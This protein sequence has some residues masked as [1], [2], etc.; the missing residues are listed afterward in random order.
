M[1]SSPSPAVGSPVPI[2]VAAD[3]SLGLP[4]SAEV[5]SHVEELC[6][7]ACFPVVRPALRR[8]DDGAWVLP[9]ERLDP[10]SGTLGREEFPLGEG[11]FLDAWQDDGVYLSLG[12]GGARIWF[13]ESPDARP[14]LPALGS[15]GWHDHDAELTWSYRRRGEGRELVVEWCFP[16][17]PPHW[18]DAVQAAWGGE[19]ACETGTLRFS[20]RRHPGERLAAS[21][22]VRVPGDEPLPLRR[23]FVL[24]PPL[25]RVGPD[26]VGGRVEM[27]ETA[28]VSVLELSA[29]VDG[30]ETQVVADADR[31]KPFRVLLVTEAD[32]ELPDR[33][34]R[35][36]WPAVGWELR[37]TRDP[38]VPRDEPLGV[39]RRAWLLEPASP[40]EETEWGEVAWEPLKVLAFALE[41][42]GAGAAGP[43]IE[44]VAERTARI[45]W[46]LDRL[47]P[48]GRE[49]EGA[50]SPLAV[51]VPEAV[52]ATAGTPWPPR[53][54]VLQLDHG[55]YFQ[56]RSGNVVE[57]IPL[58]DSA[59]FPHERLLL[60][61]DDWAM[62]TESG[63][64]VGDD[65]VVLGE[66][67]GH[68][69]WR[70]PSS[71]RERPRVSP[72][73]WALGR[74]PVLLVRRD[75]PPATAWGG[76]Y[77]P[78][79]AF[80]GV[81]R[82]DPDPWHHEIEP[83]VVAGREGFSLTA[84]TGA[85]L[86]LSLWGY[87]DRYERVELAF[88]GRGPVT[89]WLAAAGL[90]LFPRRERQLLRAFAPVHA[91][92]D[93]GAG[94]AVHAPALL[95]PTLVIGREVVQGERLEVWPREEALLR[96]AFHT[97]GPRPMVP[98]SF[99][100][101]LQRDRRHRQA[102]PSG[103]EVWI[104]VQHPA[105]DST[106]HQ[107]GLLLSWRAEDDGW[108]LRGLFAGVD[109]LARLGP[110][111]SGPQSDAV[112]V[113]LG[114]GRAPSFTLKV[115]DEIECSEHTP[116]KVKNL[117]PARI[118]TWVNE[119]GCARKYAPKELSGYLP[120]SRPGEGGGLVIDF[121]PAAE[122]VRQRL[123]VRAW[124]QPTAPPAPAERPAE[125][126]EA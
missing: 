85:R 35:E 43:H 44:R 94:F 100:L 118:F 34:E 51:V 14:G 116:K 30:V 71:A 61:P 124:E 33:I 58:S 22:R 120:E 28:S 123:P 82:S 104:A 20:L 65:G 16:R 56:I 96:V 102:L 4:D 107:A 7:E 99:G 69:R 10:V 91:V 24:A 11:L 55:R 25:R 67:G 79:A 87:V 12:P 126:P 121:F 19:I 83:R 115:G 113:F 23:R 38:P 52:P 40:G 48:R 54:E 37:V 109:G 112:P 105:R 66:V 26:E 117:R 78:S 42:D 97:P 32:V 13:S 29:L 68:V 73:R 88:K 98:F 18:V 103:Q 46:R 80:E 59:E 1:N 8:A 63:A 60:G 101:A 57:R 21:G 41:G 64:A 47:P 84:G 95:R 76:L 9:W 17:L 36:R 122:P 93:D 119:H 111:R 114:D 125:P 3:G 39:G 50:S 108:T 75:Q 74:G 53:S 31:K 15:V 2:T 49:R 77:V 81:E 6:R 110:V 72:A 62:H 5:R 92:R 90:P 89:A 86:W 70:L 27:E 45:A 106:A